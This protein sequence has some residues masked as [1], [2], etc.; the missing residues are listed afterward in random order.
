MVKRPKSVYEKAAELL[1][2]CSHATLS[3]IG[4]HVNKHIYGTWKSVWSIAAGFV[5]D[6]CVRYLSQ[7]ISIND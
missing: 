2:M 4:L 5:V 1:N 7:H 6:A 3:W